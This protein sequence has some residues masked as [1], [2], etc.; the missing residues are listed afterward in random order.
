M[1]PYMDHIWIPYVDILHAYMDHSMDPIWIPICRPPA[2]PEP[3]RMPRASPGIPEH[4]LAFLGLPGPLQTSQGF[5]RLRGP[6]RA[7]LCFPGPHRA[8]LG[9]PG[10]PRTS[11]GFPGPPW[12]SPGFPGRPWAFPGLPGSP[13]TLGVPRTPNSMQERRGSCGTGKASAG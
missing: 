6:P 9:L 1:D 8:S 11:Q 5:G 2:A 7:P 10:L 4:P 13:V 12:A 3:P